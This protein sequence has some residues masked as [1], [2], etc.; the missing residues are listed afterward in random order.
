MVLGIF[1]K[2]IILLFLVPLLKS[3]SLTATHTTNIQ[4]EGSQLT[5]S[6]SYINTKDVRWPDI[7][8]S[9]RVG[10]KTFSVNDT[11]TCSRVLDQVVD[12][13]YYPYI[14]TSK[15]FSAYLIELVRERRNDTFC[16]AVDI[17][18]TT[19]L[20]KYLKEVGGNSTKFFLIIFASP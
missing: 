7:G 10:K 9:Y 11:I 20:Q 6:V 16:P 12:K 2:K 8:Y 17:F 18:Y 4:N 19:T 14:T 5:R 13:E 15:F 3:P 1:V